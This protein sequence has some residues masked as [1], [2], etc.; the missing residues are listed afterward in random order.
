MISV[1]AANFEVTLKFERTYPDCLK[2]FG[3]WNKPVGGWLLVVGCA[4]SLAL[5]VRGGLSFH[6]DSFSLSDTPY[7]CGYSR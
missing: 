1:C 5:A 4:C 2:L 6:W 3:I 7:P